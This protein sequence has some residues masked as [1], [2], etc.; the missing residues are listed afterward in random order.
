MAWRIWWPFSEK[1]WQ[2]EHTSPIS[3]GKKHP[4]W[5]GKMG[6]N[7]VVW[8]SWTTRWCRANM[9]LAP[10]CGTGAQSQMWCHQRKNWNKSNANGVG[11]QWSASDWMM[12]GSMN[13]APMSRMPTRKG[14]RKRHLQPLQPLARGSQ[15][16]WSSC[17]STSPWIRHHRRGHWPTQWASWLSRRQ[18]KAARE[19]SA[20]WRLASLDSMSSLS[21]FPDSAQCVLSRSVNCW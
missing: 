5:S 14:A 3:G 12:I 17:V 18:R 8:H 6:S 13:P 19:G 1:G 9:M 4:A 7:P 15:C 10:S 20:M 2:M 11:G 21:F 16:L